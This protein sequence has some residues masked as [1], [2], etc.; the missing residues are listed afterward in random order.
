MNYPDDFSEQ[1]RQMEREMYR[2]AGLEPPLKSADPQVQAGGVGGIYHWV[3]SL[4]GIAK[5]AAVVIIG[6]IAFAIVSFVLK[7]LWAAITLAMLAVIVYVLYKVFFTPT[8]PL[9]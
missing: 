7:L 2:A 4:K 9:E 3:S 1:L 6:I 8:S 5:V